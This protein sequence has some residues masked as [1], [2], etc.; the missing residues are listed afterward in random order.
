MATRNLLVRA[1]FDA[2]GMRSGVRQ[3]NG[4]LNQFGQNANRAMS[5]LSSNISSTMGRIG[6]ILAT[7]FA[8]GAIA[9]FGKE[10]IELGS[11]LS[12]VQNVVDVTFGS[13]S[14]QVDQFA[15]TAI[16]KFGLSETAAKQY[17]GTMGAMLKSS[18]I[19]T[20]QAL[21][22]SETLTG[23]SADMASFYNLSNSEAFEKIRAGISGET[24]PLKALGINMSVANMQ[25]YALSQGITKAWNSMSQQEQTLLRYNYL[26]SVTKDV[27]GDF[28]RT[29]DSWANQVRILS[30]QFNALKASIGQGLIAAFTPIV[31]GLNFVISKLRVAAGYFKAF[32]ELIFGKQSSGGGGGSGS[33]VQE[34]ADDL[35]GIGDA[36]GDASKAVGGVGDSAEKAGKKAKKAGKEAKGA[37]ASFDEINQLSIKD[38]SE[39]SGGGGGKGSGSSG[40]ENMGGAVD[41]DLG[42]VEEG[43]TKLDGLFSGLMD[44]IKRLKDLLAT[45]FKIGLGNDFEKKIDDIKKSISGIKDSLIDIFTDNKVIES[46]KKLLDAIALNSGK[47]AG[48][49]VRVGTTIAQNLLGGLDKYLSQNKGFIKKRLVGIMDAGTDIAN[50]VGN[51]AVAFADI[52]DVFGGDTAKQCTANIIDIFENAFLGSLELATKL[53]RDLLNMITQ[54]I[55]DNKD[56]IR[57][58]LENTLTV[59]ET[60]SGTVS[61]FVTTAFENAI[62]VYDKYIQPAFQNFTDGISNLFG[63]VLDLYNQYF[64]PVFKQI[65]DSFNGLVKNNISPLVSELQTVF[66]KLVKTLSDFWKNVLEPIAGWLASALAPAVS[67][68]VKM[69]WDLVKVAVENITGAVEGIVNVLEGVIDFLDGIFTGDWSKC[70]DGIKEIVSGAAEALYNLTIGPL[71]RIIQWLGSAF[72]TAWKG[73][74]EGIKNLWAPIVNWF[75]TSV[76]TPIKNFFTALWNLL[77]QTATTCWQGIQ[78]A[79]QA[80]STWFN[81]SV[82]TPIKNFFNLMWEA[83]KQLA[84]NCWNSIKAIW[85][86]VSSWFNSAVISP[87]K[88][89]FSNAWNNIK[90]LASSCI[91]GIKS[92][93]SSFKSFIS[94]IV[95]SIKQLFAKLW[96]DITNGCRNAINSVMNKVESGINGMAD[97][98]N[99]VTGKVGVKIPTVKLPKLAR[100]GIVD[101]ATNFG[102]Y[103][104]G[105]AGPEMVVPLENT[106]FTDKIASAMGQAVMNAMSVMLNSNESIGESRQQVNL[107]MDGTVLARSMAPY[108]LKEF[109]R[110]GFELG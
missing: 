83:L 8:I 6:K 110:L 65:A 43:A 51:F 47:I 42:K 40:L 86:S 108:M 87:V 22:M 16:E 10:C 36:A 103:I 12:E 28:A 73:A 66:G 4:Y 91:S 18:G 20:K 93:F 44:E 99:S 100:G 50:I 63:K 101:G 52:F 11:D 33:G 13:M 92:T 14:K 84:S 46:A 71:L 70:W 97:K 24:E 78:A 75:N 85:Q 79:W 21:N 17:T 96:S 74:L 105:E 94:G 68:A 41:V 48:S 29:S 55:I 37:L 106:S 53:G 88:T 64:A 60:L 89:G 82:I 107:E 104:A 67:A 45:G 62:S 58:A 27:Q 35:G 54:P 98:V 80:S 81:T 25:A 102:N 2:T 57:K 38:P 5:G 95:S 26:L 90:S 34:T 59:F 30:E 109:K 49:F 15:S 7:A 69:I 72:V 23:L 39:G 19:A 1:G 3:A 76:I 56:K 61:E 32:M 77:K 9:K 31:K